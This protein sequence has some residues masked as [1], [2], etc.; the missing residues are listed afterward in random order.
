MK[1]VIRAGGVGS[2]LWPVSRERMPKQFHA[3]TSERTM[4][5]EAIDRVRPVAEV[6]DIYI[7]TNADSEQIVRER[8]AD[9]PPQNIIVEPAR[10]DTAAAIGLESVIIHKTDPEAIVAS[11]GSDHSVRRVE[12]FQ[13]MLWIAEEFVRKHPDHIIPIGVQATRPDTGYGYIQLG[14][15]IDTLEGKNLWRV[16]RFTEK[17]SEPEAKKFLQE[18]NYLWNANMFV[19]RVDTILSLYKEF[20]PEMFNQLMTIQEAL[21][22]SKE[23]ETIENVYPQMEQIAIDYAIIEK[24]DRSAAISANIGWSDVG[25]WARLKDEMAQSE[26]E[27]VVIGAELLS[28]KTTNSLV[29]SNNPDKLIATIGLDNIIIV[30]TGDALLV[31][32]KYRSADVKDIVQKLKD[33]KKENLL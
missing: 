32:D 8:H 28:E 27:N 21:G 15:V 12:E 7:S 19:W 1:I 10:K 33:R 17:P 18:S 11:L 30:D 13:R 5:E 31:C 24:T 16:D 29:Y 25:D 6:E 22:T 3:L 2:R 4:L 14:E 26:E 20:L 23:R 9:I